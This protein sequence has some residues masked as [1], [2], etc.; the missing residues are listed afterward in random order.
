MDWNNNTSTVTIV[1]TGN[2]RGANRE[3]GHHGN[4]NGN[5]NTGYNNNNNNGSNNS[6]PR[7]QSFYLSN[8][9]P[10]KSDSGRTQD[11]AIRTTYSEPVTRTSLRVSVDGRDSS[12]RLILHRMGH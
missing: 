11:P 3:N 8:E 5:N 12:R 1:S 10:S 6:G 7:N 2:G 9:T 4:R